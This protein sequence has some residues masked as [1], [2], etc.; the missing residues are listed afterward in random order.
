M[1]SLLLHNFS[2]IDQSILVDLDDVIEGDPADRTA[3][4]P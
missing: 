2:S 4:T 1:I 3:L